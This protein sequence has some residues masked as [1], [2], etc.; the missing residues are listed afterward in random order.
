MA[1]YNPLKPAF[2]AGEVSPLLEGRSSTLEQMVTGARYLLNAAPIVEGPVVKSPGTYDLLDMTGAAAGL[3]F[4]VSDT[5]I[6]DI[7]FYDKQIRFATAS[8]GTRDTYGFVLSTEPGPFTGE[9]SSEFVVT[10]PA[11]DLPSPYSAA[12]APQVRI[13]QTANVAYLVHPE[14]YPYKL[15][16]LASNAFS[17]TQVVFRGGTAPIG[18]FTTTSNRIINNQSISGG[19]RLTFEQTLDPLQFRAGRILYAKHDITLL[20]D[21]DDPGEA[22]FTITQINPSNAKQ[23]DVTVGTEVN[24][25]G[26]TVGASSPSRFQTDRWA[27]EVF[28][29]AT[30]TEP[31]RGCTDAF[32]FENRLVYAGFA[33]SPD[34]FFASQ[35][36]DWESFALSDNDPNTPDSA[37]ADKAITRPLV[38]TQANTIEW[39]LGA[40]RGMLFG[41]ASAEF[42]VTGTD[43]GVLTPVGTR[44]RATTKVGSV[45]ARPAEVNGDVFFIEAGGGALRRFEYSLE[46]DSFRSPDATPTS[47]HLAGEG[48]TKM[49]FQQAPHRILWVLRADGSFCCWSINDNQDFYAGWQ[50]VFE[51]AKVVDFWVTRGSQIGEQDDLLKIL[52]DRTVNGT[53]RR[54]LEVLAPFWRPVL[55]YRNATRAQKRAALAVTHFLEGGVSFMDRTPAIT[56]SAGAVYTVTNE[57]PLAGSLVVGHRVRLGSA[58]GL[59]VMQGSSYLVRAA[60]PTAITIEN[61]DGSDVALPPAVTA[62]DNLAFYREVTSSATLSHLEGGTVAIMVDGV[63]VEDQVVSGGSVSFPDFPGAVIHIGLLY[64]YDVETTRFGGKP[65]MGTDEGAPTAISAVTTRLHQSVEFSVGREEGVLEKVYATET[66]DEPFFTGDVTAAIEGSWEDDPTVRYFDRSPYP[67][68]IMAVM[69]EVDSSDR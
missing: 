47:K 28:T 9:F 35:S 6:Y 10:P 29:A 60:T 45:S 15:V 4:V 41:T 1:R 53:V 66:P 40:E 25:G 46:K 30:D 22:F 20:E 42:V 26:S 59:P 12:Q 50:R 2:S 21:T 48:M 55:P 13:V 63:R 18:P 43:D 61:L 27:F 65:T 32:F 23:L 14:H 5:A 52:V 49:A 34:R 17:L 44:V 31:G 67:L 54:R 33:D 58:S 37:D 56:T 51:D 38:S 7:L 24:S 62:V 3:P 36:D 11:L 16:R 68:E 19:R 69:P 39:G 8:D 57:V 64:D